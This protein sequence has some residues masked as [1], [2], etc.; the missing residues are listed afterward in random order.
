[1]VGSSGILERNESNMFLNLSTLSELVFLIFEGSKLKILAP[2]T[3]IEDSRAFL[4]R[5][6]ENWTIDLGRTVLPRRPATLVK[7]TLNPLTIP[8]AQLNLVCF[9]LGLRLG[10]R[11]RFRFR[12]RCRFR[13][14][15]RFRFRFNLVKSLPGLALIDLYFNPI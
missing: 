14:S 11:F 5:C 1:M 13:F 6:E 7:S 9:K 10:L 8:S 4:T 15:F 12:C 3:P 2:F